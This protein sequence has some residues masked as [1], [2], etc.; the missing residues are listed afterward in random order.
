MATDVAYRRTHGCQLKKGRNL[1]FLALAPRSKRIACLHGSP[2]LLKLSTIAD[3]W[4][5]HSGLLSRSTPTKLGRLPVRG[6]M[7]NSNGGILFGARRV[8]LYTNPLNLWSQLRNIQHRFEWASGREVLF[9]IRGVTDPRSVVCFTGEANSGQ[10]M[11][12]RL[13]VLIAFTSEV[14]RARRVALNPSTVFR[15]PSF[16]PQTRVREFVLS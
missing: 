11:G 12:G 9:D 16:E 10:L 4:P 5:Y 8:F 13:P 6:E 1:G 2:I 7:S 14:R 3:L 15:L